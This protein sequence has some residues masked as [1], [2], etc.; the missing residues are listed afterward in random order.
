MRHFSTRSLL[1][2]TTI[3]VGFAATPAA[4]QVNLPAPGQDTEA[5]DEVVEATSE[6]NAQRADEGSEIVVT[7]SRIVRPNLV[8]NSPI[9]VVTGE[10]TV[11][12]GD[13]TL[14]TFLNTLPQVNPSGTS[15]SN[16][17]GNNGQSN[18][19]LRGLGTNRNLVLIDG[20]RPMVSSVAQAV[21]LNTIPQ[22][23]IE[24]IEVITGG[25]GAAY[26][27]DAI[28]GVANVILRR[29]FEGL[30]LRA[31]YSLSLPETDAIEYQIS[32]TLGANFS[33]GR[34]N[35]A[36]SAEF[37]D[38]SSLI[39]S[40]RAFASQALSTTGTPPVGRLIESGTNPFSATVLNNIFAGYGVPAAQ[41]PPLGSSIIGF[42]QN[43]TLFSGGIFNSP[44]DVANYLYDPTG[45]DAAAANQNFFPDFYSYN[46]DAINL[47]VLP[48]TRRSAFLR[49]NY[50]I[51]PRAE[52]FIQAG[53]TDY[54][55]DTALAPTPIGTRIY[56]PTTPGGA[57]FATSPLV[58]PGATNFITTSVVPVTNPF[59]PA[60]LRLLLNS[61][62]GDNP[63]LTG[64][65]ATEP[66]QIA[67]RTLGAGLRESSFDST[68][69]QALAGLRGEIAGDWRYEAYWSVGKTVIDQAASGNINVQRLQQLLEAPD[70]GASLCEGGYNPFGIQ[71][72]SQACI[73]YLDETGF[74]ST[75]F[76]QNVGQAYATGSL[77][78]LPAG[79][80]KA[81]LGLETRRFTYTF[82][83]GALSG[84]IAGFNTSVAVEGRNAF[85]DYFGE[86]Y[87]PLAKDQ[88]FARNL[89]VTLGFRRSR[90]S[91]E[92]V[93]TNIETPK[94]WST[95]YKVETS[96][97]PIEP[98][99]LR[100]S[101][102]R[103]VRAPNF[104]ELFSGGASFVSI[105]DPCTSG[106]NFRATRG[107]AGQALCVAEGVPASSFPTFAATPGAQVNTNFA[108][109]I[110]LR[111]EKANTFTVGG[112]FEVLGVIGSIDYYNIKIR[113]KI[114]G[115]D[116]NMLI[117]A[118]FGYL[119]GYNASLS[120]TDPYCQSVNRAG[121]GLSSITPVPAIGGGTGTNAGSFLSINQGIIKTSGI[122][123]QLAWKIPTRFINQRSRLTFDTYVNYL[124]DFTSEELPGVELDFAGTIGYFGQGVGIGQTL[125]ASYPR[126]KASS[127]IA[128]Q[129]EP[130]TVSTRIRYIDAMKNRASVQFVGEDA[131]FTGVP[132]VWYFDG[133]VQFDFLKRY[134]FRIGVNN[135]FNKQPPVYAP[136]FQSGTDPS[137]YDVVGRRGYVQARL[138]F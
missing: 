36:L 126:W 3:V 16:N 75:E 9:A 128:W 64:S 30:E 78:A 27:A 65:G 135:I 21:D 115:P 91:A 122:D 74:T 110:N 113:D 96:W 68:V 52:L 71:N 53:Y 6:A 11:A 1:L 107:A 132:S 100:G 50:E 56:N 8:A 94:I 44:I 127:N 25:A 5:A 136:N 124:I 88:G 84:P 14:D 117:A 42:N 59:I 85:L 109:N 54:N 116:T 33:D 43:G 48:L 70:G 106:S 19:N 38:R 97:Q 10:Q 4:A 83:P 63:L 108:G 129:L 35:I 2:A 81:V 125:G 55:S 37:A 40:Q 77:F 93:L 47:L 26:G 7:G 23:L 121:G 133:A 57:T 80:V 29:N 103:S 18:I 137:L 20:R 86:L 102:Q 61:R 41:R 76:T 79:M 120:S 31:G 28:A 12:S 32:G 39:K 13:I 60:D 58:S 89:D 72:I 98:V 69:T 111:P 62:T 46:F 118:C 51:D 131:F 101:F 119:P 17:P 49:A 73:D 82:D 105:F 67:I 99:R 24:R 87:V 45:G 130:F 123:L 15:T 114:F 134:T 95:A 92:N 104:G 66:F 138:K 90:S 22:G 112:V 34:G